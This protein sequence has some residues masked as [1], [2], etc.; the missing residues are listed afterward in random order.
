M[1]KIHI[2]VLV[3]APRE[4]VWA[5]YTEP[6]H[7]TNWNFASPD[8]ACPSASNDLK[9]GGKYEARMEAKDGSFGFDF[10]ATY[11]AVEPGRAF[12]YTMPDGR[13]VKTTFLAEGAKTKV[14]TEFDA[15]SQNSEE[16]QKTGWQAIL[17]NFK[18]YTEKN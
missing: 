4:K 10:E 5:Y 18:A 7:I 11:D 1:S 9:A 12:S 14:T 16:M 2:E 13:K 8:W 3:S 15:E 17:D 6:R